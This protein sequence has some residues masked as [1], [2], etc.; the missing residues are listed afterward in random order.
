MRWGVFAV[1]ARGESLAFRER[2]RTNL[3]PQNLSRTDEYLLGLGTS[4]RKSSLL[5]SL[6]QTFCGLRSRNSPGEERA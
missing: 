1:S 2:A 6:A 4:V 5:V 3:S